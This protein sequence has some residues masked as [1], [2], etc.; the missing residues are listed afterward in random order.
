MIFTRCHYHPAVNQYIRYCQ[1]N[2]SVLSEC[3]H[4]EIAEISLWRPFC[5]SGYKNYWNWKLLSCKMLIISF[6]FKKWTSQQLCK[7]KTTGQRLCAKVK[8]L[9]FHTCSVSWNLVVCLTLSKPG[10][11]SPICASNVSLGNSSNT[12]KKSKYSK[13]MQST[14]ILYVGWQSGKE[15]GFGQYLIKLQ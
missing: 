2:I 11:I 14:M 8:F 3:I 9:Y 12:W 10:M 4:I 1:Y 15:I 5:L 13:S 6:I 7:G